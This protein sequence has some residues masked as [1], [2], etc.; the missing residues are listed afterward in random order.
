MSRDIRTT[1][2]HVE[3]SVRHKFGRVIGGENDCLPDDS[4]Y[5]R[6]HEIRFVECEW[7]SGGS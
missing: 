2:L 7:Y 6:A 4:I 1:F 3:R 5:Q